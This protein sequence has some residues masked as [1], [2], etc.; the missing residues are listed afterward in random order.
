MLTSMAGTA[1]H[2]LSQRVYAVFHGMQLAPQCRCVPDADYLLC[3]I[4]LKLRP[5]PIHVCCSN[6]LFDYSSATMPD[7]ICVMSLGG[8]PHS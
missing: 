6:R 5:A 8:R 1:G 4:E 7:D 3:V 2:D